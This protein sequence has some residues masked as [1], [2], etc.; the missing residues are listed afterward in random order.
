MFEE[1][2]PAR[3][4]EAESNIYKHIFR[5]F[6]ICGQ[7]SSGQG[8]YEMPKDLKNTI[9]YQAKF[10][11]EVWNGCDLTNASGNGTIF[12]DN[13]FYESIIDN[14]SMQYC[15]FT[16]D[17]FQKCSFNG[18]NFANS[19]FTYCAIQDSEIYGCSFLGTEF[20]SGIL[21][22][23]KILSSNFELCRFRKCILE[24]IDLRE[25]TLNYAFFEDITMKNV[26]L[27]FIQMP[28]TFNGLQY[29]FNTSDDIT[30]SSHDSSTKVIKLEK[31][32][33][34]IQDF[35]VFFNDKDQYFPLT[36]C[37]VVQNKIDLANECNET[38]IKKSAVLH[39]FRSLYFYC[40]QAVQMLKMPR[41]KRILLYSK[42]NTILSD[43][44][45]TEGEY[46]QFYLYFP[47]IKK[48][49]FD[50]PNDN[51]VLTLTIHTN[52]E[53]NDY[54]KLSILLDALEKATD[55]CG[56]SLDSKHIEIRH[57]SPNVIDLF[58]SG[59]LY[60]LISNFQNIFYVLRPIIA[61]IANVITIG[62]T[63][64]ATGKFISNKIGKRQAN[65][66]KKQLSPEVVILRKELNRLLANN[67]ESYKQS[68]AYNI[69]I[70][71][72][73]FEKLLSVKSNLQQS[74]IIITNLEIHFLD[75]KEDI[76]DALYHQNI[77]PS[78]M[79]D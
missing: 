63:I 21:R 36:N 61:D 47:M 7:L 10:D 28:Y 59:E 68:P 37:Y 15:S 70:E 69:N 42:I 12:R 34:M 25:L 52:I 39:D 22:N 74:G 14:V 75:G 56:I 51:P 32:K 16:K 78:K 54:N 18:S 20:Y 30:I 71:N 23:T 65:T 38:G 73:F 57:N 31:Y 24:N 76:L 50:T 67:G 29:I 53:P 62:G 19:T 2:S 48:L 26:C 55:E 35:I 49:L 60:D 13:D 11:S 5:D 79:A 6:N 9:F 46:H 43:A 1:F 3:I 64:G 27:P 72:I 45:L 44:Q 58:S 8:A 4:N 17:I 33:E 41:E 77:C 66:H 40:I